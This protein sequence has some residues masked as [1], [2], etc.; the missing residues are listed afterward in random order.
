MIDSNDIASKLAKVKR[1]VL[2]EYD[3]I[4]QS[5]DYGYLDALLYTNELA[6]KFLRILKVDERMNIIINRNNEDILSF[7]TNNK[8]SIHNC[9]D[10]D[11][12]QYNDKYF[13]NPVISEFSTKLKILLLNKTI[14]KLYIAVDIKNKNK[15]QILN[16]LYNEYSDL[17]NI[18]D[19][20]EIDNY[21]REKNI[22]TLM[23]NENTAFR[24]INFLKNKAIMINKFMYLF[25][26]VKFND[27][28]YLISKH[29]WEEKIEIDMCFFE[30]FK[31]NNIRNLILQE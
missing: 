4:I 18:C 25:D 5:T 20:T 3:N 16:Y 29:K 21:I 9:N 13:K 11:K 10:V 24:N 12:F 8:F 31:L 27:E 30:P 28:T 2:I 23:I 7:L 17:I 22:N 6:I 19:I 26:K 15:L 1:N 14:D